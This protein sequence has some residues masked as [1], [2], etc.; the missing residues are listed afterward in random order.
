MRFSTAVA[1]LLVSRGSAEPSQPR[2]SWDTVPVFYHSCNFTG[3][4]TDEAVKIMAKFPMVTIEKGQGV[5]DPDDSRYAEDKIIDTL[6][7]VKAID[8]NISTIFYYNSVLDWP[9]YKLHEDFLQHPEWWLRNSDGTECR[10]NGDGSFP[11]HTNMLSFDFAQ[12]GARDLWADT[13]INATK[14][15]VVDGCFSD[16]ANGHPC[17]AGS[18]YKAG[19]KQVHQDLQKKL[20]NG[21]LI[22]NNV[23]IDGVGATMIEFFKADE[24]DIQ[25]V[26]SAAAKGVLMQAHDHACST[27]SLAAF[28]IGAGERSYYAC[29]SGWKVQA[30][31]IEEAWKPEYDKPLGQPQGLA[32]KLGDVY[33]RHFVSIA[34]TTVVKFDAS[35]NKGSIEWAGEPVP[36]P[37]P[38]GS[39]N[40]EDFLTETGVTNH[41]IT[42]KPWS[43][44]ATD[45]AADCCQACWDV[46]DCVAWTWY[47]DGAK[48]CHFHDDFSG[49]HHS[50]GL[51]RTSQEIRPKQAAVTVV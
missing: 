18:D 17:N 29:T 48:E 36:S 31:P 3:P 39:C 24:S 27:D 50:K 38:A 22:S 42:P 33:H 32:V 6:R 16:R 4:Y 37:P 1:T 9:F 5:Q 30:D 12:A 20:G 2:F 19:H 41:D 35:K 44:H 8:S 51:A 49:R 15:G 46:E 26:S 23:V 11:N 45:S 13:C 34:G 25:K 28:L 14:S 43:T 47:T 21:V 7:R 10:S 40:D